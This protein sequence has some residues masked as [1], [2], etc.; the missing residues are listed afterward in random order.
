LRKKNNS[1]ININY[2]WIAELSQGALGLMDQNSLTS[3]VL[4]IQWSQW[5]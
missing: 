3:I 2:L 5:T 4:N 1:L